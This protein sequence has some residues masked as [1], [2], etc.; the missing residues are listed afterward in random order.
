MEVQVEKTVI[1]WRWGG[2][3]S[4]SVIHLSLSLICTE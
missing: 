1:K 4:L 3:G 2:D